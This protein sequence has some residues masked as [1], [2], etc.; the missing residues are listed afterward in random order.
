MFGIEHKLQRLL[1]VA[2]RKGGAER[3]HQE[4]TYLDSERVPAGPQDSPPL[5]AWSAAATR[6]ALWAQNTGSV[7][8]RFKTQTVVGA[9]QYQADFDAIHHEFEDVFL[10]ALLVGG[11]QGEGNRGVRDG[12]GRTLLVRLIA[13]LRREKLVVRRVRDV[14]QVEQILAHV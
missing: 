10:E 9:L 1:P 7:G 12:G 11:R 8:T 3:V 14:Q 2:Q 6:A 5:V 4:T 13:G